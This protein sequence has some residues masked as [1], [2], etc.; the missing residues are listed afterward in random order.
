MTTEL[1]TFFIIGVVIACSALSYAQDEPVLDTNPPPAAVK[2][3]GT[4]E[5]LYNEKT[6][7]GI[8]RSKS[9]RLFRSE[10]LGWGSIH[11]TVNFQGKLLQAPPKEVTIVVFIASNGRTYVD[12]RKLLIRADNRVLFDGISDLT[13]ARTNGREVYSSMQITLPIEDFETL[14]NAKNVE[15][16]VGPTTFPIDPSVLSGFRDLKQIIDEAGTN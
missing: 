9:A 16:R 12:D 13:D 3:I 10:L 1:R 8:A 5:V 15:V 11:S 4:A 14:A 7:E 6:N 2:T